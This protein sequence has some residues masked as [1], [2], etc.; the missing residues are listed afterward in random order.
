MTTGIHPAELNST[1]DQPAYL[2]NSF[3]HAI[4]R[5]FNT[6]T[7]VL[8]LATGSCLTAPAQ[9]LYISSTCHFLPTHSSLPVLG[10][11]TRVAYRTNMSNLAK[12]FGFTDVRV[13]C[14]ML[15][16]WRLETI[17]SLLALTAHTSR[18]STRAKT[19]SWSPTA[20]LATTRTSSRNTRRFPA[21][22]LRTRIHHRQQR[23]RIQEVQGCFR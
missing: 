17:L 9:G 6:A 20:S 4:K 3:D 2:V 16:I 5:M 22:P 14:K 1:P 11:Q 23:V 12:S 19:P 21:T 13:H 7:I 8:A 15:Q 10:S 18:P